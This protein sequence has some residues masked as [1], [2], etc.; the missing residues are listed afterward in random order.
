MRERFALTAAL[1]F[2][3]GACAGPTVAGTTGLSP[4][5]TPAVSP[6]T[7]SARIAL[8]GNAFVTSAPSGATESIT[9]AGLTGWTNASSITSTYF[10]V[11]NPGTLTVA[12]RGHASAGSTGTIRVTINGAPF[13]IT[14]SGARDTSIVAGE[15]TV[16]QAGYVTVALQGLSRTGT[17]FGEVSA[18]E[19]AGTAAAGMHYANDS[20]NY[21]WSRRGPS[22]HLQYTTP[23]NTEYFYS[24]IT[25]PVGEDRIGSYFMANG[26]GQGYMGIQVNSSTERRVLFSVWDDPAGAVTTLASK[27]PGVVT[28]NFSGEGTGGQSYLVFNWTA[29][30][31]YRFLTRA[32]PD[33]AGNTDYSAWFGAP[34]AAWRL[35]A[36]WKRPNISTYLTGVH[37]FLE[38]F[39]D[40]RGYLDRSA[41]YGNQWARTTS[42]VWSE[43]VT[44]SLSG[45]ATARNGQR[46][47]YAGGL[48]NGRFYLRNGGFFAEPVA[49]GQRFTRAASGTA[50][51]VDVTTLP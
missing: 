5:E 40:T 30:D 21:Y 50:P 38:N 31:T 11:S 25:V 2:W 15:V 45:D 18:L 6:F 36:T 22:V 10:R 19:V 39:H 14:L 47:D 3:L 12:V 41:D 17:S 32:R 44:A 43:V 16:T 4:H 1:T 9:P 35:I 34:G 33:G 13:T 8:A 46:L 29:G 42:G 24:E 51:I 26:F 23:A 27:G 28:G 37:S 48:R 49:L 7:P 20:A